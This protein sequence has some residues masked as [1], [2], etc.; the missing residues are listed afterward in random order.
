MTG[1]LE[2]W[3]PEKV[4]SA[5]DPVMAFANYAQQT[6]GVPWPTQKDLAT[7][8]KKVKEFFKNYPQADWHTL[9]RV[10]AWARSRKKRPSRVYL[11]I[12]LFRD[13]W[14]NGALPELDPDNRVDP[15]V[16]VAIAQA[17]EV[18][19]DAW[20]CG[21]LSMCKGE[22]RVAALQEW[23]QERSQLVVRH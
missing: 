19:T 5:D 23:R 17:L 4:A 16:E 20:W 22:A 1:W 14:S 11:V 8:R 13:A 3:T 12:E 2:V 15:E 6:L 18:E 9:C 7:T 21:R 10:V